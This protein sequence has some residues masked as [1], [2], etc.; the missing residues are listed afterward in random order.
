MGFRAIGIEVCPVVGH[1]VRKPDGISWLAPIGRVMDH[2][3]HEV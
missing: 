3:V 2:R 1:R